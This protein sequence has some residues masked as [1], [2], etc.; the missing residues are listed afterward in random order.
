MSVRNTVRALPT[1]FKVSF[2]EAV[3]YRAEMLVWVLSTTM[4]LVMYLLWSAVAREAPVGRFG[5]KEFLAYFLA[6]FI[7][8]QLT[9]TWAAWQMNFEIR[10][11]T[12]SMKLLRPVHVLLT[13]ATENLA[14][15]P[16]RLV[17][18][19]PAAVATLVFVGSQFLPH[20]PVMWLLFLLSLAGGWLTAFLIGISIGTLALFTKSSLKVMDA[21]LAASFV[22]SG[23]LIPVELF[24]QATREVVNFLPFRF[25]IGLPVELL[26]SRHSL[27]EALSLLGRQW[28]WVVFL[29]LLTQFMWR[30]GL[31][32]FEAYGG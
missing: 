18:S 9:G 8:R 23:Y 3:A 6:A 20:P 13:Y 25:T 29:L 14:V 24:P 15:I 4:P 17:V 19:V 7:V 26:T 30:R 21:Y 2:A 11:G 27:G 5:Q 22:F 31:R 16:M 28:S 32:R 10:Q 1:L 12:L